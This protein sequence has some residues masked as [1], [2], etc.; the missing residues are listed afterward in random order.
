M[1]REQLEQFRRAY[2]KSVKKCV[3]G[4]NKNGKD[5]AE[6][7]DWVFFDRELIQTLLDM[8]DP[9]TGGLKMYFGQYDKE[10]LDILPKDRK[11]REDYIGRMSIAIAAANRT[12]GGIIDVAEESK[13]SI[14]SARS[15]NSSTRNG[16]MLCPPNCNP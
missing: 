15:S 12:E 8:T 6:Q 13:D 4:K 14:I 7:S 5:I 10:N 9:K 16:G 1:T 2:D 11:D 3:K